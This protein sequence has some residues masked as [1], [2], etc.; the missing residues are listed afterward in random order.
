MTIRERVEQNIAV[1]LLGTLLTGF[2]SGIAAYKAIQ[3]MA[4]LKTLTAAEHRELE[5][6]V[7]RLREELK[8]AA[9]RP[10]PTKNVEQQEPQALRANSPL[11]GRRIE[12]VFLPQRAR[13]AVDIRAKLQKAGMR[14]EEFNELPERADGWTSGVVYYSDQKDI[15]AALGISDLLQ[16]YGFIETKRKDMKTVPFVVCVW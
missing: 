7:V 12:I 9:N 5:S 3:E 15:D 8:Q 11:Q 14:I 10:Q 4:G 1:W 6:E 16:S 13:E 2:L